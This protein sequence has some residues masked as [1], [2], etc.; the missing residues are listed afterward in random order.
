M[1]RV[2]TA[3]TAVLGS[4][5]IAQAATVL[6]TVYEVGH[7]FATPITRDG[8]SLRILIDTGAGGRNYW[9]SRDAANRLELKPSNCRKDPR[10]D[11]P[12]VAFVSRPDYA[13]RAAMPTAVAHCG[14]ILLVEAP[15][16]IGH[17]DGVAGG[18]YLAERV[19]TF[20]YP[21]RQLRV[22]DDAWRPAPAAHPIDL[23]M[24]RRADGTLTTA[25]PRVTIAVGGEAIDVL[26]DTGATAQ[27]TE[28]GLAAMKPPTVNG[29]GVTS[30][31]TRTIMNRWHADHPEW[32]MIEA[33]DSIGKGNAARAIRVPAV[34]IAGWSVSAVWFTERLDANFESMMSEY[35]DR[36]IHGAVGAN[37]LD[38]FVMTLDYRKARAWLACPDACRATPVK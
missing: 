34:E 28:A 37:V 11:S 29:Q 30:Y 4:I 2:L 32:P 27:P 33:A 23:G 6:P 7:F 21:A 35:T 36:T 24:Q 17:A 10:Y 18:L 20:D 14:D 9:I 31:I 3:L 26:L 25:Y 16:G 15:P 5:A 38:A 22:E 19:W 1:L 12:K 13:P 8:K